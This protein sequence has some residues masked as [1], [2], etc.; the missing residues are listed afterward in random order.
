M[1]K[2]KKRKAR[3]EVLLFLSLFQLTRPRITRF[4][5]TVG[6]EKFAAFL[7]KEFTGDSCDFYLLET[8][9]IANAIDTAFFKALS[10]FPWVKLDS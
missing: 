2:G 5:G 8:G 6:Q 4:Y 3:P 10:R 1:F 7:L 9:F